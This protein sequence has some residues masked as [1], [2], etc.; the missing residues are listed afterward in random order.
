MLFRSLAEARKSGAKVGIKAYG[1]YPHE[2]P[3]VGLIM[4]LRREQGWGVRRIAN[5]M[6]RRG[7][8]NRRGGKWQPT[9]IQRIFNRFE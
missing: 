3:V 7:I 1:T 4:S 2:A 8:V 9:A 5:E 6:N